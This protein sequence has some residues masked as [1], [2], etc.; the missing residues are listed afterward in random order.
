MNCQSPFTEN[1]CTILNARA[2]TV[3]R[4]KLLKRHERIILC[5]CDQQV[6]LE[7]I[8]FSPPQQNFSRTPMLMLNL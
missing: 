5:I 6:S 2:L 3:W 7:Q 4:R 8:M 1:I